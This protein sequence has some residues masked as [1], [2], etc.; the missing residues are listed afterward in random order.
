M[1]LILSSPVLTLLAAH[2]VWLII[3]LIIKMF[4]YVLSLFLA[5]L[6]SDEIVYMYLNGAI[7]LN[8]VYAAIMILRMIKQ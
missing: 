2:I 8:V 5:K 4:D 7:V 6:P 1:E 3:C